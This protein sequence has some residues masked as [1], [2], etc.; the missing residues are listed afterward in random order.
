M[1]TEKTVIRCT[2]HALELS[3]RHYRVCIRSKH[4]ML[5]TNGL[6]FIS[7]WLTRSQG[8]MPSEVWAS[9][10]LPL[11]NMAYLTFHAVVKSGLRSSR[12]QVTSINSK[13]KRATLGT[14]SY[15]SKPTF[16]EGPCPLSLQP[17]S[18]PY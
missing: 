11:K 2:V 6:Y 8:S 14:Q 16:F 7:K 10:T 9:F 4:W 5:W 15:L 18:R 3:W 1:L 17:V 12:V 13:I